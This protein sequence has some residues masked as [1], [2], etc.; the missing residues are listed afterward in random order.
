MKSNYIVI[1]GWMVSDLKLAGNDLLL[2]GL[3][4]GFCQ[5]GESEFKGSIKYVC[6]WLNCTRPTAM[7]ALDN[8]V[9][10]SLITKRVVNYNNVIFNR[11]KVNLWVVKNIDM[12]SK[13]TLLGD[14]KETLPNNTILDNN[15]EY[16]STK[17]QKNALQ[18]DISFYD[19][20]DIYSS[21]LT[22][23]N[24]SRRVQTE[25]E[26]KKLTEEEKGKAIDYA[27]KIKEMNKPQIF[28]RSP[29]LLLKT[30]EFMFNPHNH[31]VSGGVSGLFG[32]DNSMKIEKDKYYSK[33]SKDEVIEL[34]QLGR[35]RDI[36][37]FTTYEYTCK[38]YGLEQKFKDTHYFY[39]GNPY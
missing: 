30:K 4:Y 3:I 35:E 1:Q 20:W 2:Y 29:D 27:R 24:K 23:I 36:K 38:I 21:T 11:Y 5:D 12:G 17:E 18:A 6:D 14:S 34:I 31:I 8:L 9:K 25:K 37:S 10:K 22:V 26:W 28:V 32:I 39:H 15:K 16:I 7:K 13:E 33:Q 19:F